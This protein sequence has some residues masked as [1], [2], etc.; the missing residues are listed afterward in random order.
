MDKF[1]L[2][3]DSAFN[4]LKASKKNEERVSDVIN[5]LESNIQM[6]DVTVENINEKT[7]KRVKINSERYA[8][9]ISN[10]VIS[11]LENAN[12]MAEKVAKK[13]EN[14]AKFSLLK[15]SLSFFLFFL[16]SGFLLWFFFIK[17]I[18]TID[19]INALRNEKETLEVEISRLKIYGDISECGD[20]RGIC[21]K[22]DTS[23]KYGEASAPY[24]MILPKN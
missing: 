12:E 5:K 23:K 20:E 17:D 10:E 7:D 6:L 1:N 18:P 4:L 15:L 16:L 24:Y 8:N 11:K 9:I 21:I 13:Y 2:L 3:Y 19:E 14:A 22:V